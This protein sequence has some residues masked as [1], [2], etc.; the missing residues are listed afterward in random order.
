MFMRGCTS[1]A[2]NMRLAVLD[3]S[4][5]RFTKIRQGRMTFNGE[6]LRGNSEEKRYI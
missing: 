4:Q 2:Y 5:L 3:V 6:H 1:L